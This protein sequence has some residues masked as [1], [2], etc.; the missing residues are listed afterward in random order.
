[1]K[2]S[3]VQPKFVKKPYIKKPPIVMTDG[4]ITIALFGFRG[5]VDENSFFLIGQINCLYKSLFE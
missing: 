4:L 3:I 2:T 1:M 5:Y